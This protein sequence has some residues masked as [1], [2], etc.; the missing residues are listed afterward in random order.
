MV[1][2]RGVCWKIF[3]QNR[4]D[5][6]SFFRFSTNA[7]MNLEKALDFARALSDEVDAGSSQESASIK[8]T[9]AL[10]DEVDARSSQESASIKE[11]RAHGEAAN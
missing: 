5:A 11:T 9:R 2:R 4:T 8:E 6:T 10:S 3:Q 7:P 1:R